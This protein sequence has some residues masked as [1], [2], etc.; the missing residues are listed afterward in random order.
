MNWILLIKL[1]LSVKVLQD[2][3]KLC[4]I[5]AILI[6]LVYA[7]NFRV[8]INVYGQLASV[9]PI[10]YDVA[11]RRKDVVIALFQYEHF[12]MSFLQTV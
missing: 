5:D 10:Q 2:N 7:I 8:N 12:H 3:T 4:V 11:C 1:Y 6:K 9:V